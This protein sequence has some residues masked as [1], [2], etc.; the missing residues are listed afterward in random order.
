MT[1]QGNRPIARL[2]RDADGR[3][4]VIDAHGCEEG[5]FDLVLLCDGA[6]STLRAQSGIPCKATRYPWGALWFIGRR[7]PELAADTLWQRV[8]STATAS[9]CHRGCGLGAA[10]AATTEKARTL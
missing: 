9:G 4:R 2:K 5:P 8:G 3:C 10:C 1:V 6:Q 7:P